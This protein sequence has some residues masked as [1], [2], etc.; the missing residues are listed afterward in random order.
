[1]KSLSSPPQEELENRL[2]Q[3]T[4]HLIQKQRMIDS[5]L[6]EKAFLQL[7]LETLQ[8]NSLPLLPFFFPF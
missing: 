6:G 3:L 5:L 7:Q 1:V 4:E 8:V 2:Q